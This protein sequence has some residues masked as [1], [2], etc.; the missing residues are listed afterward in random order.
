L[1]PIS[2]KQLFWQSIILATV[3]AR[4]RSPE[5]LDVTELRDEIIAIADDPTAL[6]EGALD[7]HDDLTNERYRGW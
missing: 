3:T 5:T 2:K 1:H 6:R 4:A 7:A